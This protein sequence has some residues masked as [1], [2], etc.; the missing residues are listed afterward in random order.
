MMLGCVR[1]A[2]KAS[3]ENGNGFWHQYL[4]WGG[5]SG[6]A[7]GDD[8]E[9]NK[10]VDDNIDLVLPVKKAATVLKRRMVLLKKRMFQEK[11]PIIR[12]FSS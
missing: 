8:S 6:A 1:S 2:E 4:F 10:H 7:L 9:N 12:T 3:Q 5:V 11:P